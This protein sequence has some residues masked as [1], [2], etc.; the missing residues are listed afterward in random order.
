MFDGL[1]EK[2]GKFRDDATEEAVEVEEPDE[3]SE[4]AAE[5]DAAEP[6]DPPESAD[7]A[8]DAA[9]GSAE[10][11]ADAEPEAGTVPDDAATDESGGEGAE[12]SAD[13]V[14]E[15]AE[16][17]PDDESESESESGPERDSDVPDALSRRTEEV[18]AGSAEETGGES[19][20]GSVKR[21]ATG[22]AL[23]KREELQKPLEELEMALIQGDVE[24]SVAQAITDRIEEQL[25]GQTRA[26]VQTGEIVVQRAIGDALKDVISVGQFDFDQRIQEADK[27]VTI[28]FTGVNGVGKTTTIAKLARRFQNQGLTPVIA[29][30]DTY[31]AG[32]NEQIEEHAEALDAKIITH[33]QGGDPAA[34]IYD[35]VEYA[36]ANDADVVLGDTAGR[37]HTSNDLMAQLEKIDRVVDPDMTIFVDEAVAGQDA[38]QRAKQFN[39]A[40]EIDGVVLTK[41][42]ADSQGGAAVSIA[43]VTGKPILFLGV[44]QG[45]EDLERFD[46]DVIVD[47][48]VGEE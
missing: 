24:M 40:A 9:P 10:A 7:A 39:D 21:A 43:H 30:G 25:V 11:E 45:Y 46:P 38:T 5:S 29:N 16:A 28:I 1:K 31:R 47:R 34:V 41:A 48:I 18:T 8:A 20:F 14:A 35:A 27:P 32:A 37:L 42:D 17:A 33:Q 22:K 12:P 13:A 44:G 3:E 4:A 19:L 23:I 2:L 6:D 15:A 26:Q 36:E